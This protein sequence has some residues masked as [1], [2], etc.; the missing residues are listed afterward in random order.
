MKILLSTDLLKELKKRKLKDS[1]TFSQIQ[2]QLSLF[3]KESSHPSLRN[4]KL[5][6]NLNGI[7]SISINKSIRMAYILLP[8]DSAYFFKIGKH[9]EIY[10]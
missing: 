8:N 2:K 5:S 9:E 10:V 1:K 4:H 7:W 3:E 6:G